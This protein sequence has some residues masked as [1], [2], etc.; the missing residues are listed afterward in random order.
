MRK[1]TEHFLNSGQ[2]KVEFLNKEDLKRF[3]KFLSGSIGASADD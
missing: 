2:K 3:N 1:T